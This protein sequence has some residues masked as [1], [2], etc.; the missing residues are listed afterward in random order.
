MMA[1]APPTMPITAPSASPASMVVVGRLGK[2]VVAVNANDNSTRDQT[3]THA[4]MFC[5]TVFTHGPSTAR[6]LHSQTRNTVA[7][8][9]KTPARACT[10][11]VTQPRMWLGLHA[12]AADTARSNAYPP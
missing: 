10:P 11:W 3:I 9:S 5:R 7:D 2:N 6:S 4:T 12:T 8:G 1:T